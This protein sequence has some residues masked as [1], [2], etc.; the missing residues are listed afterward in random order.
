[1][2]ILV[3]KTYSDGGILHLLVL[4]ELD[5]AIV[6]SLSPGTSVTPT[7]T[8]DVSGLVNLYRITED[9]WDTWGMSKLILMCRGGGIQIRCGS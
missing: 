6:Y 1:M 4:R 8:K 2:G 5:R 9:D 3:F 7:M